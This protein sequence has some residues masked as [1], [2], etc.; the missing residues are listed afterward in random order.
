MLWLT[1]IIGT[2]GASNCLEPVTP[3][4]L[5]DTLRLAEASFASMQLEEFERSFRE[6]ERSIPCLSD[7]LTADQ[8]ASWH[9]ASALRWFVLQNLENTIAAYSSALEREPGFALPGTIAP[10][11]HPLADAY[12][13][14]RQRGGLATFTLPEPAD[15]YLLIDGVQS[16]QRPLHR[17]AILQFVADRDDELIWTRL[18]EP[19][20]I[21]PGWTVAD[22]QKAI[23]RKKRAKRRVVLAAAT[24]GLLVTSGALYVGAVSTRSAFDNPDTPYERLGSLRDSTNALTVSS[25]ITGLGAVGLGVTLAVNW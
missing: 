16:L 25:L 22:D 2:A 8:A 1:L 21:V 6:A 20:D 10:D 14:A 19:E 17:P 18:I 13:T 9:R 4:Q 15:A 12:E 11:G 7:R 23:A 5:T 3:S 24:G